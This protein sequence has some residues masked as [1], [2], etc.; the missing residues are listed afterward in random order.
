M[1][2]SYGEAAPDYTIITH[3]TTRRND[4][5]VVGIMFIQYV[6]G[7]TQM[8]SGMNERRWRPDASQLYLLIDTD[9]KYKII[10]E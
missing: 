3:M 8:M 10:V 4:K 5:H 6:N 2:M 7:N 1:M 9:I